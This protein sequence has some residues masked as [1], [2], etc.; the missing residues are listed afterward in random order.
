VT[1]DDEAL[2]PTAVRAAFALFIGEV[3]LS[4]LNAVI[5][6]S[7]HIGGAPV[8]VGSLLEAVLFVGLGSQMRAG[9]LWARMAL[10]SFGWVFIAVGVLAVL[11]LKHAFGYP[12]GGLVLFAL[13][14]VAGKLILIVGG[15]FLMYRSE[16]RGYFR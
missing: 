11:E 15:V 13:I 9:K 6:L 8:L 7:A 2:P 4:L 14:C 16:T 10:M 5:Q 3:V 1:A 12:V